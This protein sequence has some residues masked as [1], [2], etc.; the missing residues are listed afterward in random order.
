MRTVQPEILDSLPAEHAD[1]KRARLDL[2]LI[3][4]LMGNFRWVERQV[5][6]TGPHD[7]IIELGAGD[8]RLLNRLARRGYSGLGI[9]LAPRPIDLNDSVDWL[10]GDVLDS[11]DFEN[12]TVVANLFLHHLKLDE[13]GALGERLQTGRA[14]IF[15]EPWRSRVSQFCGYALFPFVNHVTRHDMITS[16]RA[17]FRADELYSLLGLDESWVLRQQLSVPGACRLVAIR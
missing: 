5:R 10:Q 4:A 3:N 2:R 9:D 6:A 8:G 14:L 12:A 13:L 7:R 1:A 17:G 15:S 11:S 16:I